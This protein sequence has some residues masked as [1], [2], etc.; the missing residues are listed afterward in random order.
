MII[1]T[2][3]CII[4]SICYVLPFQIWMLLLTLQC[5]QITT[6]CSE[7]ILV[8]C[9]KIGHAQ[10]YLEISQNRSTSFKGV[11][12]VKKI[13]VCFFFS[14]SSVIWLLK[15]L[16]PLYTILHCFWQEVCSHSYLCPYV[17]FFT[18]FL[19]SFPFSNYTAI[20]YYDVFLLWF[21]LSLSCLG[22]LKFLGFVGCSK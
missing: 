8:I 1:A 14:F 17:S 19:K 9:R 11:F 18:C 16:H 4:L 10:S 12:A 22:F 5:L 21:T 3:L 20:I 6:L 13:V 7:F 2:L 15:D